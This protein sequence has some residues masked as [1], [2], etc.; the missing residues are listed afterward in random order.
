MKT[1]EGYLETICFEE[2]P[3]VLDDDMSDFFNNWLGQLDGED[4]IEYGDRYGKAI[5]KE[6]NNK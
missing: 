5:I 6:F 3:Q 1:F 2:N 4:Y